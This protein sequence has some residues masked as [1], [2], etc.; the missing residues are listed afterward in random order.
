VDRLKDF[1]RSILPRTLFGRS[2]MII[3][4]PM[5]LLQLIVAYV[6]FDRHWDAMTDKLAVSLAG[7]IGL[8][9][10][11]LHRAR[12]ADDLNFIM[13]RTE[14]ML[15][16]Q[17][18]L[19]PT[20]EAEIRRLPKRLRWFNID[21]KLERALRSSIAMPYKMSGVGDSRFF[22][23]RVDLGD[24]T[25]IFLCPVKRV[26][27]PTTYVFI[28]WMI[29][30]AALLFAIA[31]AFMRNQVRPIR[32]LAIAA[33]KFGKGQEVASFKLEGAT[34]V[35]QASK[36]FLEM[37]SRLKRQLEQRTAM[38]AGV[39]HDLRTP[40]TR[41][42]LEIAMAG[43][44]S[45]VDNL[46]QDIEEME[47]MIEGYIA[48]ARGDGDEAVEMADMR[49]IIDRIVA[50]ARRQGGTLHDL[51]GEALPI[52]LRPMAM[53]RAISNVVSN[54]CKYGKNVWISAVLD[55]GVLEVTI[56]DDGPGIAK[57]LREDAFRPFFRIEQSRNKKTGGLGLGLAIAQDIVHAHGGEIFLDDSAH[58]GLKAVIRVPA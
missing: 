19:V 46:R 28:L 6:F 7:E 24:K 3:L 10:D 33:E 29:G 17:V 31:I 47:K 56:E 43:K 8:V 37:K 20:G 36:A 45:G 2:L 13:S 41:M 14:E 5:L 21:N 53:E 1:R 44:G 32:R 22:Q 39:S 11:A 50:N 55:H 49:S 26:A 51:A 30:G 15:V 48:F 27:S 9:A 12:T 16:M 4:M 18:S 34:E 25:A 52:R 54:A 40:L 58:G 35:R 57:N 42:K 38:L 23:V